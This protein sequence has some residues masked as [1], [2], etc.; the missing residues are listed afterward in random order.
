MQFERVTIGAFIPCDLL[1]WD[2]WPALDPLVVIWLGVGLSGD[3][4]SIASAHGQMHAQL[5][6]LMADKGLCIG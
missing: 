3:S 6:T 1:P 5:G 4:E 2:V